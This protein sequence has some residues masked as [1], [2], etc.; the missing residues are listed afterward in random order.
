MDRN[1]VTTYCVHVGGG[2]AVGGVLAHTEELGQHAAEMNLGRSTWSG[3]HGVSP[4]NPTSRVDSFTLQLGSHSILIPNFHLSFR[5]KVRRPSENTPET[6]GGVLDVPH[7][8]PLQQQVVSPAVD[9]L[10]SHELNTVF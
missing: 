10:T 6:A 3:R 9:G 2:T 1:T 7:T 8:S 4:S 5:M